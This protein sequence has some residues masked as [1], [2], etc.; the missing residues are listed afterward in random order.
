MKKSLKDTEGNIFHIYWLEELTSLIHPYYPQLSSYSLQSLSKFQG[1]FH[2]T[3]KKKFYKMYKTVVVVQ[4]PGPVWLSVTSQTQIPRLPCPL[5]SP[6]ICP[7]S[8]PLNWW[9][10]P[11]VSS[12]VSLFLLSSI[13]PSIRVFSNESTLHMRWPKYWSFSFSIIPS[14]EHPGLIS[15]R[16]D[17]LDLLAV[18]GTLKSSPTP[19]FKSIKSSALSFLHSP[20]LTSIHAE[21]IYKYLKLT[22]KKCNSKASEICHIYVFCK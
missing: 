9:W 1:I 11:N 20:T 10:H 7:S 13:F 15:F 3:E 8:C 17:W 19:Q 18:Q 2:K 14:K 16:M 4:L 22:T 6:R 12:S 5:P 21:Y